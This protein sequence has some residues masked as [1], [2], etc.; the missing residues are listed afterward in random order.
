MFTLVQTVFK[1]KD[2]VQRRRW[3]RGG[4]AASAPAGHASSAD[5]RYRQEI[6]LAVFTHSAPPGPPPP[7][8]SPC[9]RVVAEVLAVFTDRGSEFSSARAWIFR[10]GGRA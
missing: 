8:S 4:R 5:Y 3:S 2:G 9:Q 10:C 6:V 1:I 7:Q